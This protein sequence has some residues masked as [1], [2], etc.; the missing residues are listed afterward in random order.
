[1]MFMTTVKRTFSEV[2]STNSLPEI[3]IKKA[4]KYT[5]ACAIMDEGGELEVWRQE[6][7]RRYPG[8]RPGLTFDQAILHFLYAVVNV[9]T[10]GDTD[11]MKNF[12]G[13]DP[14]PVFDANT[15]RHQSQMNVLCRVYYM[16]KFT[17]SAVLGQHNGFSPLLSEYGNKF[18]D[19]ISNLAKEISGKGVLQSPVLLSDLKTSLSHVL[20]TY[21]DYLHCSQKATDQRL[22]SSLNYLDQTSTKLNSNK[23]WDYNYGDFILKDIE[24]KK[25][26]ILSLQTGYKNPPEKGTSSDFPVLQYS[27]YHLNDFNDDIFDTLFLYTHNHL[28]PLGY[29]LDD[30]PFKHNFFSELQNDFL[31][32]LWGVIYNDVDLECPHYNTLFAA[33]FH[34]LDLLRQVYPQ[35]TARES[36]DEKF[37][38]FVKA[39]VHTYSERH[40]VN[41]EN[42]K[43]ACVRML[44]CIQSILNTNG[45]QVQFGSVTPPNTLKQTVKALQKLYPI[46]ENIGRKTKLCQYLEFLPNDPPRFGTGNFCAL[47]FPKTK[48]LFQT[49][50]YYNTDLPSLWRELILRNLFSDSKGFDQKK[51]PEVLASNVEQLNSLYDIFHIQVF[52][53]EFLWTLWGKKD[54]KLVTD[55]INFFKVYEYNSPTYEE[56]YNLKAKILKFTNTFDENKRKIISQV[57]TKINKDTDG[58]ETWGLAFEAVLTWWVANNPDIMTHKL[59]DVTKNLIKSST[60]KTHENNREEKNVIF[61]GLGE[62]AFFKESVDGFFTLQNEIVQN[63]REVLFVFARTIPVSHKF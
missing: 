16:A 55:V 50:P 28:A 49:V 41:E 47:A 7:R 42:K 13:E 4:V 21:G 40:A 27:S 24:E 61:D 14:A 19:N 2:E 52:A 53:L 20:N 18:F 3:L 23:F 10:L 56:I 22:I 11:A 51:V 48:A 15:F 26:I 46:I 37:L 38:S 17:R 54:K 63:Y 30:P 6:F 57:Y 33:V 1:M 60:G 32:Y 45:I 43:N 34:I 25:Q 62:I 5:Q 12:L 44:Q 58:N 31:N 29:N 9:N 59:Q 39:F 35:S 8:Q 36:A